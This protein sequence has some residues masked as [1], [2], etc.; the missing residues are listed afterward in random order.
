MISI[1]CVLFIRGHLGYETVLYNVIMGRPSKKKPKTCLNCGQE[2]LVKPSRYN[3]EK[4]CCKTCSKEYKSKH[5]LSEETRQKISASK[6]GITTKEIICP[7]CGIHKEVEAWRKAKFCSRQCALQE[8]RKHIDEPWNK[9]LDKSHPTIA[10]I[11]SDHSKHMKDK[12][13][14]GEIET[15]NK[16]LTK[17]TDDRVAKYVKTQTKIRNTDGPQKDKWRKA[18]AKGQVKAH[19]NGS[20]DHAYTFTKPEQLTWKHLESLGYTVKACKDR[21]DSD[22]S[23]TWYHQYNFFD[24][25]VPD[26]ACPDLKC[27]IEVHG[28]AI[29]GHDPAKCTHRTSQYG[30]SKVAKDNLTRDRKKYSM[31]HRQG[32]KWAIIWECEAE[33]GDFHRL[34]KYLNI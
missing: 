32:W 3:R 7:V 22:P 16:G 26:F 11:S 1:R 28:C 15:W 13:D 17:D 21:S 30:W 27:V 2:F 33:N 25:F 18:L 34:N 31:Y 4:C 10:K 6:G 23:N 29:H 20:Y 8:G 12:Y 9:G 19:A 24:A 5:G 14:S